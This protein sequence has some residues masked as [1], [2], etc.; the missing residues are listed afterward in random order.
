MSSP[1]EITRTPSPRQSP[2]SYYSA[3]RRRPSLTRAKS[4]RRSPIRTTETAYYSPTYLR[5]LS[6]GTRAT[7]PYRLV[8]PAFFSADRT[9]NE[10]DIDIVASIANNILVNR[11]NMRPLTNAQEARLVRIL[12]GFPVREQWFNEDFVEIQMKRLNWI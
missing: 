2:V 6:P 3:A 4:P 1:K 8:D 11:Y 9:F 12:K 10:S 5:S 7:S